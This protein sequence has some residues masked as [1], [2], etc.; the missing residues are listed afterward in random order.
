[1]YELKFN[2]S[3]CLSC[4]TQDCLTRCQYMDI[5]RDTAKAEILKIARGEDSFVLH[6][7][8]TCYA[9]EEYCPVNN[10]P[11]YLIVE[12]QEELDVPP[13][14][15]PLI[16]RGIQMGIP[17]RG[18][19]VIDEINGQT[20]D[21]G[22]FADLMYLIQGKLFEGL[23][24]ISTDPRKMFHYFCQ[25]MY[26]H[27]GRASVIKER[28]P[29]IIQ[30]IAKHNV[31]E[32][33]CFHD[34]CYGTYTSYCPAVGIEVPFKSIH[35]FEFLYNRLNEL[36]GEITPVNLKVAYQ[37]PCSSRLSSDKHHFVRDIFDLIGAE[38]V[39]REYVDENALCC[40]GTIQGQRR[41]GSRK[42]TADVQKRNIEDI[43]NAGAEICVFN[44]PA[45]YT[46]MGRLVAQNGIRPVFMSDLCRLAIGEKP[47]GWR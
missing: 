27:Y 43:K 24:V 32:V 15:R 30:T 35:F 6:D 8:V 20:L 10:H 19:P 2:E 44:C 22:A 1:M 21:M 40:G 33:I 37:R 42:R 7:C 29:G 5:D 41:E 3:E 23:P 39:E 17:F 4:A 28:L 16:R 18:E 31:T 36:K 47:A 9:C 45:C 12:K 26:L 25:L 13:L 34:E 11:F 46:T 38:Y 14:P